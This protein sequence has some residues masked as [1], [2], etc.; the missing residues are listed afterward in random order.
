MVAL[1]AQINHT[2]G[3]TVVSVTHDP[4]VGAAMPRTV[5]IRDGR[6]GAEGRRGQEFAVVGKDGSVQ[7]PPDVLE[8]LPPGT[9]LRVRRHASGVD[10]ESPELEPQEMPPGD[11]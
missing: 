9:L 5:T 11:S 2:M 7:L 10:L 3:A 8:K 1:L 4:E 6:I